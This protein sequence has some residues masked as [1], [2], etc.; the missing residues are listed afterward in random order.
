MPTPLT[1]QTQ[2]VSFAG[3]CQVICG[4]QE[5]EFLSKHVEK[6][7]GLKVSLEEISVANCKEEFGIAY[8]TSCCFIRDWCSTPEDI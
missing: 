1:T 3:K 4:V 7:E 5:G 2:A 6:S 8:I